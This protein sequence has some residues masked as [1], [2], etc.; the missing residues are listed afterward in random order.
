LTDLPASPAGETRGFLF[1]DLRGYTAFAEREGDQAAADLLTEYRAMVR[2][3]IPRFEGA[4]IR[5]EGDSFYVVFRS[6]STA[7]RAGLEILQRAADAADT[8]T[9]RVAIGVHA[10]EA[11]QTAEG[12]VG[13]AV[14]VA[15]R[16]CALAGPGELFVSETARTIARGQLAV[17]FTPRGRRRLKG[18]AE[19]VAVYSVTRA[20]APSV[21]RW[22][23]ARVP[24]LLRGRV[25]RLALP[26]AL[27]VGVLVLTAGAIALIGP[28]G[29]RALEGEEPS[30]S[31]A[32][33]GSPEPSARSPAGPAASEPPS[34][35]QVETALRQ[36]IDPDVA[37]LCASADP[38]DAPDVAV[39]DANVS[40]M[41]FLPLSTLGGL[42]CEL[43]GGA[44]PD[45]V[46]Y[47]RGQFE[48]RPGYGSGTEDAFS[49]I[50]GERNL[51][52]GDCASDTRAWGEWEFLGSRGKLLCSRFGGVALLAWTYSGEAVIAL[53]E[54]EDVDSQRLYRWW[55][56]HARILGPEPAS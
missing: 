38:A 2:E 29:G 12:Y 8:R 34:R 1:A 49:N 16:I 9:V 28:F 55:L 41:E 3:V 20:V 7:I 50:V 53:A 40:E 48:T 10:G 37:R 54:R 23:R 56:D 4:E 46:Y 27:A 31:P 32:V 43:G 14:N 11:T 51:P 19:P 33:A 42:R 47:W 22:S 24:S 52:R 25:D 35:E 45:V 36:R 13:S 44:A 6:A 5:T 17:G 26:A 39:F 15:A 18:I 21:A 30:L